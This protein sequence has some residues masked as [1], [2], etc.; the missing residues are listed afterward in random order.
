MSS[1]ALSALAVCACGVLVMEVRKA[2]GLAT[3][4]IAYRDDACTEGAELTNTKLFLQIVAD[5]TGEITY[6]G[7]EACC[8]RR[9]VVVVVIK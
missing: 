3:Q 7:W 9:L 1:A 6:G 5:E 2:D 4:T 8:R